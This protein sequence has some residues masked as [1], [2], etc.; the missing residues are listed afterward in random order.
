MTGKKNSNPNTTKRPSGQSLIEFALVL[1][2]LLLLIIGAMDIGRMFFTKIVLT[3]AAREGANYLALNKKEPENGYQNTWKAIQDEANS[4]GVSLA[5]TDVE[6]TSTLCDPRCTPGSPVQITVS[7]SVDL[8]F[9]SFLE[10]MGLIGGPIHL[11]ST[12][13]MVAQ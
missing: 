2:V 3:N 8:V 5:Y 6:W 4:S 11:S 13:R 1:P 7:T 9:S 12:V 10:S